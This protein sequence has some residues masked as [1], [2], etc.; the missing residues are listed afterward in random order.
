MT[1]IS[2]STYFYF[3][4]VENIPPSESIPGSST[5]FSNPRNLVRK[6][7]SRDG[8]NSDSASRDTTAAH[9]PTHLTGSAAIIQGVVPLRHKSTSPSVPVAPVT[10]LTGFSRASASQ[11]PHT[12]TSPEFKVPAESKLRP[13]QTTSQLRPKVDVQP[14]TLRNRED[15]HRGYTRYNPDRK[16]IGDDCASQ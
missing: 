8:E 13:S 5:D 1:I 16:K 12:S 9:S 3:Q 14:Q 4:N 15:S 2:S 10:K 7:H 11:L 6:S